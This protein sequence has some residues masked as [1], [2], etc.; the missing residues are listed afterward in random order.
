MG[1]PT[2]FRSAAFTWP[3]RMRGQ[4]PVAAHLMQLLEGSEIREAHREHDSRVQERLVACAACRRCTRRC[5]ACWSMWLG[6]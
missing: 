5:R 3:G 2:A 1:T 4:M 6:A